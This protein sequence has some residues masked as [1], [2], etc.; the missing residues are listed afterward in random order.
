[1]RKPLTHK[2]GDVR[3]LNKAD[4]KRMRPAK[5]VLPKQFLNMLSKRKRGERGAQKEPK[6]ISVTVRYS[7]E[8]IKYFKA[9]SEGWQIRMDKIL[10]GYVKK[11]HA[12]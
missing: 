1:M 2:E 4:F 10:K 3:E 9:T 11:H 7:P 6:K 12:A 5:E 8:V